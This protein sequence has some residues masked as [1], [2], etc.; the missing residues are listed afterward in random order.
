ML[1]PREMNLLKVGDVFV[2]ARPTAIPAYLAGWALCTGLAKRRYAGMGWLMAVWVGAAW[3]LMYW[4]A[5]SL[6]AFGHY[7]SGKAVGAPLDV[8]RYD[9][10]FQLTIYYNNGVRPAQHFWRA[11]GGPIMTGSA[12][13]TSLN[14]WRLVRKV[15]VVGPLVGAFVAWNTV[16]LMVSLLPHPFVDGGAML[17]ALR[18]MREQAE[19]SRYV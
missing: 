5:E 17:R 3:C 13:V 1:P 11:A 15:P 8:V 18:K 2:Q 7:L 10:V 19:S 9:W 4:M 14:L 6:H 12:W 16:I